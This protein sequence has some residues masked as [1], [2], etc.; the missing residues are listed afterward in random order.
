MS[1]LKN[2]P[3]ESLV[4]MEATG[5]YHYWLAQFLYKQGASLQRS[6]F[7]YPNW[8]DFT[9]MINNNIHYIFS[10]A[11]PTHRISSIA[12][13]EELTG[14]TYMISFFSRVFVEFSFYQFIAE[15]RRFG[16][17]LQKIGMKEIIYF[18][19][20]N[21]HSNYLFYYNFIVLLKLR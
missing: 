9:G 1:F 4:V 2:L 5:Y 6:Q 16:K 19:L 7:G 12:P 14:C 17:Q 18:H 10:I 11:N 21:P 3:K 20:R 8:R 15:F 13:S